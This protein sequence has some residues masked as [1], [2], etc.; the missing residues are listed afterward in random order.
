MENV[1]AIPGGRSLQRWVRRMLHFALR[2]HRADGN[3]LWILAA[4]YGLCLPRGLSRMRM[5]VA[6][7]DARMMST[8]AN[9]GRSPKSGAH[10][11]NSNRTMSGL[12]S[13]WR[14]F[15]AFSVNVMPRLISDSIPTDTLLTTSRK[16][17]D[18]RIVFSTGG[19][20]VAQPAITHIPV[21]ADNCRVR[22]KIF[23]RLTRIS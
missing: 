18:T 19:L 13:S 17:C 4:K 21:M 12:I 8:C 5:S 16:G 6:I 20:V 1:E 14:Y 23:I 7:G 2:F 9:A 10:V 15:T 11:H 3:Q 22:R